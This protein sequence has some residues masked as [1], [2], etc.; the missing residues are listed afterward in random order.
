MSPKSREALIIGFAIWGAGAIGV[1]VLA[2]R[3]SLTSIAIPAAFLIAPL[4]WFL[5]HFHMR[6]VVPDDRVLAALRFGVIITAV[7]VILDATGLYTEFRFGWLGLSELAREAIVIGLLVGYACMLL[8][9]WL[10][11]HRQHRAIIP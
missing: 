9:P 6:D 11:A 7:Q 8:V 4:V 3:P 2:S 10:Q 1:V 5:V